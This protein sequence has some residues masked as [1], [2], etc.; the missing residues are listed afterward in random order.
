MRQTGTYETLGAT[1]YFIPCSLLK[2]EPPL[3][4]DTK[5]ITLYGEAIF[6]LGQL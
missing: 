6:Y 1:P 3:L 4:L 2:I 5:I